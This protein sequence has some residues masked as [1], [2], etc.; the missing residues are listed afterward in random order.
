METTIRRLGSSAAVV[1]VCG[2]FDV[3][4]AERLCAMAEALGS[5]Q[6][7]L[8]F[9]RARPVHDS[10]IARLGHDLCGSAGRFALSGLS[11]H[12]RRLLRYMGCGDGSG[13]QRTGR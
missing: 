10:A 7:T 1:S 11:E 5:E 2:S 6:V 8:D 13:R 9:Y 12:H 4:D 3:R